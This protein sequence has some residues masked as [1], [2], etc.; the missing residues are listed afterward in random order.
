MMTRQDSYFIFMWIMCI[1][2]LLLS[3]SCN[4]KRVAQESKT[5][6]DDTTY[7]SE[8]RYLTSLDALPLR[9]KSITPQRRTNIESC[10]S[11][12]SLENRKNIINL[13]RLMNVGLQGGHNALDYMPAIN[14]NGVVSMRI[15]PH[16]I[17]GHLPAENILVFDSLKELHAPLCPETI[18]QVITGLP[19][20]ETLSVTVLSNKPYTIDLSGLDM[21][22]IKNLGIH[23]LNC[24]RIIFPEDNGIEKLTF[25]DFDMVTLDSSFQNLKMLKYFVIQNTPIKVLDVKGMTRLETLMIAPAQRT[26]ISKRAVINIRKNTFLHIFENQ[27]PASMVYYYN[28]SYDESKQDTL[29]QKLAAAAGCK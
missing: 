5:L 14:G 15:H 12:L 11:Y 7:F 22:R 1:L 2:V 20:L 13:M 27:A 10:F 24:E 19:K 21:S 4:P 16:S 3:S 29:Y 28:I 9:I 23:G 17:Y 8:Y 26:S 18:R 6:A 25:S